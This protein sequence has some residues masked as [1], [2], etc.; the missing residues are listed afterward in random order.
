MSTGNLKR[1][2]AGLATVVLLGT[3]LGLAGQ[4]QAVSLKNFRELPAFYS[5]ATGVSQKNYQVS[6]AYLRAKGRLSLHGTVDEFSA[7]MVLAAVELG[8]AYC[9]AFLITEASVVPTNRRAHQSIDFT[10]KP[11]DLA[12]A[13]VMAAATIEANLFWG[14]DPTA[15]EVTSLQAALANLQ[16]ISTADVAGTKMMMTA[17]CT[18]VATS[19]DALIYQ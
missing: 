2:V 17:L 4:A 14:R 15:V 12:V 5:A 7:P 11:K 19:L 3:G 10:K 6:Q 9:G 18:E 13:D 1:C 8:G 16:A